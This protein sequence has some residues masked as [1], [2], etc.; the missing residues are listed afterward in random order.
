MPLPPLAFTPDT[1]QF[2]WLWKTFYLWAKNLIHFGRCLLKSFPLH[3]FGW[4]NCPNMF[5]YTYSHLL[6]AIDQ[7]QGKFITLNYI[8]IPGGLA[9]HQKRW[10]TLDIRKLVP[11]VHASYHWHTVIQYA[12]HPPG[13]SYFLVFEQK[14]WLFLTFFA[15]STWTK[16]RLNS[17]FASGCPN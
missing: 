16:K 11:F 1:R 15:F 13:F 8:I 12:N 10:W 4:P 14:Y 2:F 3:T 9:F 5:P 17:Y 7:W 6:L